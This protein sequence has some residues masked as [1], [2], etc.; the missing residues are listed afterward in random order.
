M[1]RE[2]SEKNEGGAAGRGLFL[3]VNAGL[4]SNGIIAERG[5]NNDGANQ[6][7]GRKIQGKQ[8]E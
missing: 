5:E 3:R 7:K 2:S 6:G 1:A 4:L 8:R